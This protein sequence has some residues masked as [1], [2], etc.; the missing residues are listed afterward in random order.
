MLVDTQTQFPTHSFQ[1]EN[2]LAALEKVRMELG[3]EAIIV[4]TRKVA[5]GPAWQV[6]KKPVVEV[7]AMGTG[8][9]APSQQSVPVETSPAI[10]PS[11]P[12]PLVETQPIPV[13]EIDTTVEQAI[14]I[15]EKA[16]SKE[17]ET[18]RSKNPYRMLGDSNSPLSSVKQRLLEQGV[19]GDLVESL[20]RVCLR[21]FSQQ[22]LTDPLR[23][24]EYIQQQLAVKIRSLSPQA[25]AA[26]Q[27]VSLVGPSGAGKTNTTAKLL[28]Y[29]QQESKKEL[30][31]LSADTIRAG[32]IAQARVYSETLEIP[33]Q[34]AYG[35]SEAA[36]ICKEAKGGLTLVDTPGFTPT[37]ESSV[38][39]IGDM[40][41]ALPQ[42]IT[43]LVVS[44]T[45]KEQDV[46][47]AISVLR[48]FNLKAMIVT[49]MD[50]TD[51]FGSIFNAA[52]R[53]HLP[54]AFLTSGPDVID[55]LRP[56]D[57]REFVGT[58]FGIRAS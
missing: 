3:P 22:A 46:M 17:L 38:I 54:L 50:A 56:A 15:A 52:W 37:R 42:Q 57:P 10:V 26:S 39:R 33:L 24:N 30:H 21:N 19:D 18:T 16:V 32:A 43:L 55:D 6:W 5:S 25:V 12:E 9:P 48:P 7:V 53:S 4:S 23:V 27:V 40:L 34:L 41:S 31:W 51:H 1:A 44:A 29:Y 58:L 2:M 45:E 36:D 47:A 13:E 14:D 49:K 11:P 35:P 28:A 8:T 20:A